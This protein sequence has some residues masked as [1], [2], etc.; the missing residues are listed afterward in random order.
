MMK[1]DLH[2]HT[3][4]SADGEV[5][6]KTY[7]KLA[8]KK[9]LAG[10]AVTDHNEVKGAKKT[11]ELAKTSK[12]VMVVRGI[13]VSSLSGH[14]L[15]Y[16]ISETI[17]RGLDVEDTIE[18][19][20]DLGGVPVAAHPFRLASGLGGIVVKKGNFSVIEVLNHRSPKSENNRASALANDL[21][22]GKT[23]GSDAHL[24][25][26]LGLAATEFEISSG[27]ESDILQE[28]SKKHTV[29]IGDS[30]TY[31]QGLKMYGKLVAHWFKRGFKR[32]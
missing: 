22:A 23:G 3:K 8:K 32:V 16:G 18:R 7:I 17:P 19:I 15:G 26:E 6:P 27:T 20:L 10:F 9:A 25:W 5:E 31:F 30:S 29:P 24:T 28:I 1:L 2:V 21:K 14:I 12:N 4:Y 13:E 11:F